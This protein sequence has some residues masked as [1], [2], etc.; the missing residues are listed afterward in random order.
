MRAYQ[1][2]GFERAVLDVDAD[3]PTGAVGLY[4]GLGFSEVNR[5]VSLVKQF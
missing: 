3:S 2:E 5:S 1:N 4:E